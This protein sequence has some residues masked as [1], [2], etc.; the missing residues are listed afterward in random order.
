MKKLLCVHHA[1]PQILDPS[2]KP[3]LNQIN[4]SPRVIF[5]VPEIHRDY[6]EKEKAVPCSLTKHNYRYK[7]KQFSWRLLH[8]WNGCSYWNNRE[9]SLNDRIIF[10]LGC[11]DVVGIT[12]LWSTHSCSQAP[13][14][15]QGFIT[16]LFFLKEP[17]PGRRQM[18]TRDA[19]Y[20]KIKKGGKKNPCIEETKPRNG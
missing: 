11:R 13:K 2:T 4:T 12:F 6:G 7:R 15:F 8:S 19:R 16:H 17:S 20:K 9:K 18:H 5:C 10:L 1:N 3:P 14:G